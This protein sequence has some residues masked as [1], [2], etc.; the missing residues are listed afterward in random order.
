MAKSKPVVLDAK[1]FANQSLAHD[2]FQDMLNKYVPGESISSDD[3]IYL[4]SLFKRHPDYANK[5]GPGVNHFEVTSA[6]YGSQCFCAVLKN[7]TKERFSY[8]KCITQK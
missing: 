3:S 2:F 4:E 6:D 7:G 8:K 1:T 5:I